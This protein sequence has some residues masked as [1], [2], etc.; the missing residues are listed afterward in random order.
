[1]NS[2][3]KTATVKK[4]T[5]KKVVNKPLMAKKSPVRG[6][7]NA[8]TSS[9]IGRPAP[10]LSKER[11]MNGAAINYSESQRTNVPVITATRDKCRIVHREFIGNVNSS[12]LFHVDAYPVNP[13]ISEVFPWLSVQ[14]YA[15]ERYRFNYLR[16][17]IHTRAAT[18]D[19][20]SVLM[21]PE[22][23]ASAEPP[24]S[25][26]IMT[27]YEDCIE[28][29]PWKDM[30]CHFRFSNLI[31]VTN[32]CFIRHAALADG[33]DV[34]LYDVGI[35]NLAVTDGPSETILWGKLWVEYDVE[36]LIPQLPSNSQPFTSHDWPSGTLFAST[37]IEETLPMG[38]APQ[39]QDPHSGFLLL[40]N[41][42]FFLPRSDE[43]YDVCITCLWSGIAVAVN[44]DAIDYEVDGD[45]C[46]FITQD[47]ISTTEY[48]L[49]RAIFS[50]SVSEGTIEITNLNR[51]STDYTFFQCWI[52]AGDVGTLV[53]PD[54]LRKQK[55]V[56]RPR[57]TRVIVPPKSL[58]IVK[59]SSHVQ[60]KAL[61]SMVK[62]PPQAISTNPNKMG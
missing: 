53:D 10:P 14:A 41:S 29:A 34:K 22:Y 13:G 4:T 27:S 16:F 2:K 39:V 35:F 57:K 24:E 6:V 55:V 21:A 45:G 25:E 23:N 59:R 48:I 62:L 56:T 31:G 38:T 46:T 43:A 8:K 47:A 36:F 26:V 61:T 30:V 17:V 1:M 50:K 11:G 44:Q 5:P 33:E 9:S 28:S 3:K 42:V 32:S 37:G 51:S 20:G 60:E 49:S 18:T 12:E 54:V 40:D 19:T 15:W 52:T 58:P 7:R